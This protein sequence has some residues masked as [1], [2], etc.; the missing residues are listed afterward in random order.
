MGRFGQTQFARFHDLFAAAIS[1]PVKRDVATL[2]GNEAS[3]YL[4]G[5]DGLMYAFHATGMSRT[6]RDKRVTRKLP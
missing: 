3:H 5:E 4:G 1:S 6:I 2:I